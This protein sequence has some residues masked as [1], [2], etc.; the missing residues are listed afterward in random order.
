MCLM[1][2]G[3]YSSCNH[4][5]RISL[6]FGSKSAWNGVFWVY[7]NNGFTLEVKELVNIG[8]VRSK[9]LESLRHE[10]YKVKYWSTEMTTISVLR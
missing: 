6:C 1:A 10:R 7:H 8:R 3:F 9:P 5:L 2:V 4:K